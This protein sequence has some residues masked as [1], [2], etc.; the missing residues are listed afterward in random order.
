VDLLI[1]SDIRFVRE[2]LAQVLAEDHAFNIV[3]AAASA[4]D[5]LDIM[6][7]KGEPEIIVIDASLPHGRAAA[8]RLHDRAPSAR[9]IAFALAETEEEV[10]SWAEA[11]ATA[12]LPR[13]TG[14]TDI[15]KRL[16][17]IRRGEQACAGRVAAGLLRRIASGRRT[18]A[19][20]AGIETTLS[21]L[22]IREREVVHLIVSG[23]SNKEI[24]RRLD[25]GVSTVKSHVHNVLGKLNLDRRSKLAIWVREHDRTSGA[26]TIGSPVRPP[27]P[28]PRPSS[29]APPATSPIRQNYINC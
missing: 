16:H 21:L 25:I 15:I 12:Y 14:L 28:P 7:R 24:A 29:T 27:M 1:L 20:T 22:T 23:M 4:D 26:W 19:N 10:I 9:L 6:D 8:V 5:V 11:G 17:E 3:G 2:G 13:T 18:A